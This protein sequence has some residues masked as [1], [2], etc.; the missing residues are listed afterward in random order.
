MAVRYF[1]QQCCKNTHCKGIRAMAE[2]AKVNSCHNGFVT[3]NL[4]RK[5][6]INSL[7][8]QSSTSDNA[9][10]GNHN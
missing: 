2:L 7:N 3:S 9:L 6:L 4:S 10:I 8:M 1:F 5:P